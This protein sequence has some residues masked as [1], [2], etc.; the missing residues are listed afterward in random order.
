MKA[1]KYESKK[2]TVN[3]ATFNELSA[4]ISTLIISGA[5]GYND[6]TTKEMFS[7]KD[8]PALYHAAMPER[9]FFSF[10]P[11]LRFDDHTTR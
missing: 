9:R 7:I 2:A 11:C 4:L 3:Q 10:L 5:K 1:Q 8:G 6:V